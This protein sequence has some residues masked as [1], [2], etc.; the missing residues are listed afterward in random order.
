M[1]HYF[2]KDAET[3]FKLAIDDLF[4]KFMPKIE[5]LLEIS[6]KD[7]NGYKIRVSRQHYGLVKNALATQYYKEKK[8]LYVRDEKGLW[9]V[10]DNSLNLRELETVHKE[11]AREDN[12]IV[13]DFFND[14]KEHPTTP[15]EILGLIKSTSSSLI[16]IK[17]NALI[18]LT[19]QIKLHLKVQE[20]TLKTLKKLQ[21]TMDKMKK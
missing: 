19:E 1:P 15:S 4:F 8:K 6:L 7:T 12:M 16:D 21:K 17:E 5:R 13:Q 18:P 3:T 2:E 11:T 10:I 9:F 14:L 20:E